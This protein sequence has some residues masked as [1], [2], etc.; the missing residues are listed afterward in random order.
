MLYRMRVLNWS[1][2]AALFG[3]LTDGM[4]RDRYDGE[5]GLGFLIDFRSEALVEGRFVLRRQYTDVVATPVGTEESYDRVEYET[6]QFQASPDALG[7]C[8][9]NPPRSTSA[10]TMRLA[11]LA[12]DRLT[13]EE[14]NVR[15]DKL[16]N[17]LES[18][19]G[20]A[21]VRS[22]RLSGVALDDQVTVTVTA[23]GQNRVVESATSL[24]GG[25][26]Y[27]LDR[28]SLG[29]SHG[30]EPLR[31]IATSSAIV[32]L[33]RWPASELK[34]TVWDAIRR[35]ASPPARES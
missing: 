12:S 3:H 32:G 33:S 35:S 17:H 34:A 14:S 18:L 1:A 11:G 25:R 8:L 28:I 9:I 31:I 6:T 24:V 26:A 2:D 4:L 19:L 5:K 23:S 29:F 10:F 20:P 21:T 15:L 13:V 27:R 7:L 16:Q 30:G 22:V